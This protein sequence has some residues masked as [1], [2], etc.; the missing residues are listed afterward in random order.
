MKRRCKGRSKGRN[1]EVEPIKGY[2]SNMYMHSY[3]QIDPAS[4]KM[5][6]GSASAEN[7]ASSDSLDHNMALTLY[8]A[9]T[10]YSAIDVISPKP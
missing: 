3:Y 10:F 7:N 1:I 8:F 5:T 2:I 6:S 9:S 4:I